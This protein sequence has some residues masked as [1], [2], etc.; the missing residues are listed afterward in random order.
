[1]KA[2]SAA[3]I[4]IFIAI[5]C[6]AFSFHKPEES[7]DYSKL[8]FQK[9]KSID[10]SLQTLLDKIR[11]SDPS[12]PADVAMLKLQVAVCRQQ[13]KDADLWLRYLDHAS[14]KKINGPLP[15]EWETEVFEKFERPYKRDG[16]GLTLAW[17]YLD[18]GKAGK[19]SLYS[20]ISMAKH[21]VPAFYADSTAGPVSTYHHFFLCNRL[22]LLNLG[23]IYTTGFECPDAMAIIPELKKMMKDVRQIYAAYNTS[24]PDQKIND[25]FL[26]Q[27]EK[28][29]Q[30]VN[31]Q[32]A[33]FDAFDHFTFI[34]D[35]VNPLFAL[36]Q[37]MILQYGVVSHNFNDYT[38]NDSGTSIFNK[39]LFRGQQ[40]RG[41]YFQVKDAKTME[42]IKHIGK[43]LF[44][45]P[46]LSEN[47]ERSCAS[48][49]KPTEFFTDT[50]SATPLRFNRIDRLPRN[51][52]SLINA[53]YN[54]L[55]MQ[56]GKHISLQGQAKDVMQNN[57]EMGSSEKAIMEKVL[58]CKEYKSAFRKYLPYAKPETTISLDQ[59]VASI[60]L[61]Y[62]D[63]SNYY[64]PFDNMMNNTSTADPEVIRGFNLFMSK[65][66]CGTCHFP[67]Q[68]NGSK[69]PYIS[70]EF[71]V[72]GVPSD[73]GYTKLSSDSGRYLIN[74]ARETLHA[75]RTSGL[76]NISHTK[77]YMHNGVFATLEAVVDFYDAGGGSGKGLPVDNQTLAADSLHLTPAEKKALI[78][79]MN[80]LSE[81]VIFDVPPAKLPVSSISALNNRKPGGT[82]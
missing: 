4:L 30:F 72:L 32:P 79:F 69:P 2:R 39:N 15:V 10:E 41:V 70:S 31:G 68:F 80:A 14:Y 33:N 23:A 57:I 21:A 60:V 53:V 7:S 1:M 37:R 58:S 6:A 34:R 45:D 25:Q 9:L 28:A 82:Y 71:E 50:T 3:I 26:A 11:E 29:Y 22:Y 38:L 52:P 61:Y 48:C 20:L 42:E 67:P 18:E 64:S 24:F 12:S 78:T 35:Y 59:V 73:T 54:H 36:N 55:I 13:V 8:Y 77:P 81:N 5:L 56:D 47:N 66:Q 74:P 19:D 63:F 16:A 49:H 75:F 44:Y 51:T 43:L 17:M 62:S 27:Y 76:K 65:A 46:I 40:T